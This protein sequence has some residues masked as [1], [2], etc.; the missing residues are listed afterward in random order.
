MKL[1]A[2]TQVGVLASAEAA[3]VYK[4]WPDYIGPKSQQNRNATYFECSAIDKC[5]AEASAACDAK[6]WC[7]SFALRSGGGKILD[8]RSELYAADASDSYS[9]DAW[10]L[11]AK[12][13][14]VPPAPPTPG[15]DPLPTPPP[16][17]PPPAPPTSAFSCA[18]HQYAFEYAQTIVHSNP[19]SIHDA[20]N[21]QDCA[22]FLPAEQLQANANAL[23]NTGPSSSSS[24]NGGGE[25]T[26][27]GMEFYVA[28]TGS[29]TANGTLAA[30]FATL[31]RARDAIRS[32]RRSAPQQP[33][34]G[35]GPDR[36]SVFVRGGTYHFNATLVLGPVDSHVSF[37]A[38]QGERAVLS[39]GRSLT[40]LQ[41]SPAGAGAT[42]GTLVANVSLPTRPTRAPA[43]R[44]AKE[45]EAEGA[46]AGAH[47]WGAGPALVNQLFVG[48]TRQVRARYPNGN[49][50]DSSG[51]CFSKSQHAGESCTW[52][53][54]GAMASGRQP[55]GVEV[56]TLLEGPNRGDSPTKGCGKECEDY[57]EFKMNIFDPP[58]GHPVY[59]RPM[60]GLGWQNNSLF[61]FWGNQLFG[62][63]GGMTVDNETVPRVKTW[64]NPSTGVVHMFHGTFLS[65]LVWACL[66][67]VP[68]VQSGTVI[69]LIKTPTAW[70]VPAAAVHPLAH[71]HT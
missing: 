10:T 50:A 61:S 38:Y 70:H 8:T 11:W 26:G 44:A 59:D 37:S 17:P 63:A 65:R 31:Q 23:A 14:A 36:A 15:P 64:G 69:D 3:S 33:Q 58:A 22:P 20:L 24:S 57:G 32:A 66:G 4:E 55:A 67:M 71:Q 21:L 19:K 6:V 16:G 5:V 7:H 40:G 9:N 18:I 46:A 47:V 49:P 34:A 35:T 41:W 42:A 60:P 51:M 45:A 39:G 29:D 28:A 2:L 62:R 13:K 30:P 53:E 68:A 43:G 12:G 54:V 27:S 25:S 52:R 56:T 48:G 1:V